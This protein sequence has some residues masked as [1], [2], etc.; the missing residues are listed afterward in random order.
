LVAPHTLT[1]RASVVEV[2]GALTIMPGFELS[3]LCA[4]MI[5]LCGREAVRPLVRLVPV[6]LVAQ[7]L[8]LVIGGEMFRHLAGGVAV[9]L[10]RAVSILTPCLLVLAAVMSGR[11]SRAVAHALQV[12]RA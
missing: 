6:L 5:A 1:T 7:V 2:Q 8:T 11:R 10:I 3:L 12:S 4:L 9:T